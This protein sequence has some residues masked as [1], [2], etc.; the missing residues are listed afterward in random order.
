[1]SADEGADTLDELVKGVPLG[2]LIDEVKGRLQDTG[3]FEGHPEESWVRTLESIG[4]IV[5]FFKDAV[6]PDRMLSLAHQ[7][8][9]LEATIDAFKMEAIHTIIYGKAREAGMSY[10]QMLMK[11][12]EASNREEKSGNGNEGEGQASSGS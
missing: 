9:A 10:P 12:E 5:E 3:V 11:I 4:N 7:V 6:D 8:V 2:E 1:M